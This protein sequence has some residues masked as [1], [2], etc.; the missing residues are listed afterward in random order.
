M[1]VEVKKL[2]RAGM[3]PA[4]TWEVHAVGMALTQRLKLRRQ[5]AAAAGKKSTTSLSLFIEVLGFEVEEELSTKA[6]QFW[7]EGVW[8][9]KWSH[10]Q[11]EAWLN[12]I[13]EV[14]MLRQVRGP[15]GAVM[16]E[17]RD[18]GIR[19]PQWHTLMFEDEERIDVRCVCPKD[20]KK[21]L[22]Q[23]ARSVYWKKYAAKHEYEELK[24]GIWLEAK[25]RRKNGLKNTEML[26]EITSG[27]RL[28]AEETLRHWLVG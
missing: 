9:G 15:A 27:R 5:M 22:V 3:M 7:A 10:E 28:G 4:R 16:R 26:R 1:K 2:Q 19:W 8:T 25:R 14:Q 21:M 17:T 24:E 18:L 11:K 6:T 13:R 12:Q 23:Q 20:V